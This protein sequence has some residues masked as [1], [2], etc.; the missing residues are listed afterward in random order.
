MSPPRLPPRRSRMATVAS[1]A[2]WLAVWLTQVTLVGGCS[3]RRD[4]F[5]EVAA[6]SPGVSRAS[7]GITRTDE[8]GTRRAP[9]IATLTADVADQPAIINLTT[10]AG[11]TVLRGWPAGPLAPDESDDHPHHRGLWFGHGDVNGIDFWNNATDPSGRIVQRS[12]QITRRPGETML[13]TTNDWLGPQGERVCSDRR[14]FR[15]RRDGRRHIIDLTITL[16][17]PDGHAAVFGDTK[18]GT[19]GIR[20]ASDMKVIADR[21]GTITTSDG[22]TDDDAWGH[23]AAWCD[24]ST[25]DATDG[26]RPAAGIRIHDHPRNF[27]APSQH[28]RHCRWHVRGYGLFAANPFGNV[29]FGSNQP[30]RIFKLSAGSSTTARYRI[31]AHD[32]G[33]D[34]AVAAADHAEFLSNHE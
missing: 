24:Y 21:G 18:E 4:N 26:D 31:V 16:I 11:R 30:S 14:H 27:V 32:G 8:S 19:L 23:R 13:A 25:T 17:A 29:A 7:S 28:D 1:L 5:D 20:V 22:H 15:F 12:A 33:L 9:P 2:V 10:P 6:G 34:R 3:D